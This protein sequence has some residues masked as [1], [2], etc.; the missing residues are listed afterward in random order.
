M[1]L[2]LHTKQEEEAT[3]CKDVESDITLDPTA[4][5]AKLET[6]NCAVPVQTGATSSGIVKAQRSLSS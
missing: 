6:T 5:P 3:G 2:D 4:N 1:V